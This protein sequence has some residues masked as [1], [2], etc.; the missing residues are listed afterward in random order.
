MPTILCSSG[1]ASTHA[2]IFRSVT[3]P[4]NFFKMWLW[5]AQGRPFKT[6]ALCALS[7]A[8]SMHL[9]KRC[10][11]TSAFLVTLQALL[12]SSGIDFWLCCHGN[13]MLQGLGYYI[14]YMWEAMCH[15]MHWATWTQMHFHLGSVCWTRILWTEGRVTQQEQSPGEEGSLSWL[16]NSWAS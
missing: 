4:G 7:V 16:H 15:A 3:W 2:M 14:K 13:R 8:S 12:A 11:S 9:G 1:T 5:A 10:Y 6:L